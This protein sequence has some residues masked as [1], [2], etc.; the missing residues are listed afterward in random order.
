VNIQTVATNLRNT[1]TGKE[2]ALAN[3]YPDNPRSANFMDEAEA[4]VRKATIE[5][6]KINIAELKRILVDVELCQKA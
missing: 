3:L 5:F 4:S 6:L 2:I 1:I